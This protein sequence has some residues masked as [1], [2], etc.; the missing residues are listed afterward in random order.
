M[1]KNNF[2]LENQ[3]QLYLKR[4]A[5][6][7]SEMHSEQQ[8]QLRQTFIGACGQMLLL[9]RDE[10]GALEDDQ[11]M[12]VMKDMLNQVS[13]YFLNQQSKSN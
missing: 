3:Y 12:E 5:L 2:I 10:V 8:K 1:N 4:V 11:A 7:E 9:L 13:N 6:K